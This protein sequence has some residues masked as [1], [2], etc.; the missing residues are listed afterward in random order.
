MFEIELKTH[1]K[2]RDEVYKKLSE[3][4]EFV[5]SVKKDDTYYSL[6]LKENFHISARIRKEIQKSSEGESSLFYLTYKKKE[7]KIDSEG[8][9]IEVNDEK[10]S[11]LSNPEALESLLF[12]S[13]FKVSLKKVKIVDG[14][15]IQTDL[16][17]CN[18]ELCNV[19][20]LGD[21]LE[22]EILC[23]NNSAETV[24]KANKIIKSYF[25][26]CEIDESEIEEKYYSQL[27]KEIEN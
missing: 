25:A 26:E 7:L 24:K 6:N 21:F 14:F 5:H 18:L 20:K 19:E 27:L 23:E 3:F 1:V 12:D 9:K 22:I 13:G 16:G 8:T 11:V 17:K 10:E 2:N 4:A 15:T